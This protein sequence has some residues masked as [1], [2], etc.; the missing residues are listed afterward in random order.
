M[1]YWIIH[2][3]SLSLAFVLGGIPNHATAEVTGL[4]CKVKSPQDD[5]PRIFEITIDPQERRVLECFRSPSSGIITQ[6]FS[7]IIVAAECPISEGG[8]R[9]FRL[10]RDTGA[11]TVSEILTKPIVSRRNLSGECQ[12]GQ[13][14]ASTPKLAEAPSE[15]AN[16]PLT[17]PSSAP[18]PDTRAP[19][20][21]A[22]HSLQRW[23]EE[24]VADMINEQFGRICRA[25]I[26]GWFSKT[27]RL[28][29]TSETKTIH[30]IT[31]LAA[32]GKSKDRIYEGGIRYLKFPNDAG[33][34]NVIDWKTGDKSSIDESAPYYFPK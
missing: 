24:H 27:L 3:A 30:A 7:E 2:L 28:D 14:Q 29:W 22:P 34:Y 16:I 20:L 8:K 31:V 25:K 26:E 19:V 4:V 32:I 21:P 9:T 15:R 33:G 17:P 5:S 6:E 1:K 13:I 11:I 18:Q 12:V 10:T 23:D